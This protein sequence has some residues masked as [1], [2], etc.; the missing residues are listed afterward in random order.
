MLKTGVKRY[1]AAQNRSCGGSFESS[2]RPDV[3][4]LLG[5]CGQSSFI[6]DKFVTRWPY[7]TFEALNV[8]D[9]IYVLKTLIIYFPI[10]YQ[11][12]KFLDIMVISF[13]KIL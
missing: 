6:D 13:Y 11:L 7:H 1:G 12:H 3:D 2:A 5:F 4:S 9:N 10:Q 8:T